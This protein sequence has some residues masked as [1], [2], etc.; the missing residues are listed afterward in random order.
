MY[1]RVWV[2][3]GFLGDILCWQHIFYGGFMALKVKGLIVIGSE[4]YQSCL[5]IIV[6]PEMLSVGI[7]FAEIITLKKI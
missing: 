6:F 7:P 4:C 1:I 5:G 3:L 2:Y